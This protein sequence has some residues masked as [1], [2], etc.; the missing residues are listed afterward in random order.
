ML[1]IY[2]HRLSRTCNVYV[3]TMH[4]LHPAL[5]EPMRVYWCVC[6]RACVCLFV[7]LPVTPSLFSFDFR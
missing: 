7:C 1:R 3:I 6:L 2:E 4:V 5:L